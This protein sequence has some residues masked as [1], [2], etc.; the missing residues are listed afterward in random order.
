MKDISLKKEIKGNFFTLYFSDCPL[1]KNIYLSISKKFGKAVSR[2]KIKRQ[3]REILKKI[4]INKNI[5]INIK[6]EAKKA[7]YLELKN[8]LTELISSFNS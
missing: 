2:N 5:K 4:Q 1:K 7:T 8:E 6:K 3:I